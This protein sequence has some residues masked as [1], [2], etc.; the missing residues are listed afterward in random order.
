MQTTIEVKRCSKCSEYLD[1]S[2]F[3]LCKS[4]YY[5]SGCKKCKAESMR[6]LYGYN[7]SKNPNTTNGRS[8]RGLLSSQ[9]DKIRDDFISDYIKGYSAYSLGFKYNIKPITIYR[10]IKK[11]YFIKLTEEYKKGKTLTNPTW[12]SLTN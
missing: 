3:Y 6:D 10:W 12:G 8:S 4:G 11:P 9:Y 7:P 5:K 1:I 2:N